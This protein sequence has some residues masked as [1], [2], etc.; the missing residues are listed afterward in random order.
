MLFRF[1]SLFS[2]DLEYSTRKS[3]CRAKVPIME[4]R[5]EFTLVHT[6]FL[7]AKQSEFGR[8]FLKI[9]SFIWES[10]PGVTSFL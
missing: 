7:V 2:I 1:L 9:I 6:S 5:V 4:I 10:V 8:L 3:W